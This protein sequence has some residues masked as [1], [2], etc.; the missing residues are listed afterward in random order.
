MGCNTQGQLGI[1]DPYTHQ[2]S[3]PVLVEALVNSKP[4]FVSCGNNHSLAL[5]SKLIN[6]IR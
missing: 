6:D 3:S 1:D 5:M 4:V 2:K